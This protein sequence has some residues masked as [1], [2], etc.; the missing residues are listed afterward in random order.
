MN[1][2]TSVNNYHL[3]NS[4][5]Q[6]LAWQCWKDSETQKKKKKVEYSLEDQ[7]LCVQI[8]L[9]KSLQEDRKNWKC[10]KL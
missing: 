4:K 7:Q 1:H 10:Q 8:L 3:G 5:L 2:D 9:L 6:E